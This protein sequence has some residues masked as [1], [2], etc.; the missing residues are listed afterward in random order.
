MEIVKF[1]FYLGI[2]YTIF[3]LLWG[4]V[5][6]LYKAVRVEVTK[7]ESTILK[8]G[9][10][11]FL[12]SLTAWNVVKPFNATDRASGSYAYI[13]LGGIVL[14]FYLIG[15]LQKS[16]IQLF[17]NQG[18]FSPEL[19]QKNQ[20]LHLLLIGITLLLYVITVLFPQIADN[21]IN[22]WF[23]GK[24][25]AIYDT[26]FL[27]FIFGIVG[28]VFLLQI[29]IQGATASGKLLDLLGGKTSTKGTG[30]RTHHSS[31]SDFDDYEIVEDDDSQHSETSNNGE[32]NNFLNP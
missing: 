21:A 20:R 7:T 23:Y 13:A 27:N 29:L 6:F 16:R 14:C 8:M 25:A 24:I 5:T 18:R 17:G 15:K 4:I 30:N 22:A 26:V 32:H 1:I 2:I 10:Y 9:S 19:N 3:G 11:Y 31:S 28:A 12:A